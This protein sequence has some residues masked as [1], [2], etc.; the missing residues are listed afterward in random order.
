MEIIIILAL[1]AIMVIVALIRNWAY[2]A[3]QS[4][5]VHVLIFI[6]S[7][8]VYFFSSLYFDATLLEILAAC[9]STILIESFL[10]PKSNK[11]NT[12]TSETTAA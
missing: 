12:A 2:K 3:T 9:I 10:F 1:V 6:L 11:K 5:L 8:S 7:A 4:K